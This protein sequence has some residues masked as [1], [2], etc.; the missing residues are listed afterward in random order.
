MGASSYLK[1]DTLTGSL[2]DEPARSQP[3]AWGALVVTQEERVTST[4]SSI[5]FYTLAFRD[6]LNL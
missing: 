4:D 3:N 5:L 2:H 6:P 1:A